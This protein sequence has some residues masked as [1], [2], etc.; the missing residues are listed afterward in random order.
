MAVLATVALVVGLDRDA[1]PPPD[2]TTEF[3]EMTTTTGRFTVE[4][5]DLEWAQAEGLDDATDIAEV[6]EFAD[7]WVAVGSTAAGIGVWEHVGPYSWE[8]ISS[9]EIEGLGRVT[10]AREVD[11]RLAVS[12]LREGTSSAGDILSLGPDGLWSLHHLDNPSP[13][14]SE[15]IPTRI[16]VVDDTVIVSGYAAPDMNLDEAVES[17][18]THLRAGVEDGS[19]TLHSAGTDVFVV[20]VEPGLQVAT[21]RADELGVSVGRPTVGLPL[22]WRGDGLDALD[23]TSSAGADPYVMMQVGDVLVGETPSAIV[24]SGDGRTWNRPELSSRRALIGTWLDRAI[25]ANPGSGEFLTWSPGSADPE[26][27]SPPDLLD[28]GSLYLADGSEAGVVA[29]GRSAFT[30]EPPPD[31]PVALSA[32]GQ[33]VMTE[34][35]LEHREGGDVV[36]SVSLHQA[37][38]SIR[39][40]NDPVLVIA[41]DGDP[42]LTTSLRQWL[43]AME[44]RSLPRFPASHLHVAHSLDGTTWS[45][46]SWEEVSG[47]PT[48]APV[49]TAH[50]TA[51]F[52]LLVDDPRGTEHSVRSAIMAYPPEP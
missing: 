32:E 29:L 35:R 14:R 41:D 11:G 46:E 6:V 48:V 26:P 28:E 2:T 21:Y 13:D 52:F 25:L 42:F 17:L 22:V 4:E 43:A 50:A 27:L 34:D 3:P 8:M 10:D 19:L 37:E 18:P 39:P 33:I 1:P 7:S 12:A 44:V 40:E 49:P 23:I 20:T 38:I 24:T 5:S 47:S 36:D 31:T 51:D 15:V 45:V 30:E 9:V 16:S